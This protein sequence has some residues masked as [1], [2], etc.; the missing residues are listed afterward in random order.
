M[1]DTISALQQ[2]VAAVDALPDGRA[3]GDRQASA[4]LA[5]ALAKAREAAT[6]VPGAVRVV[7]LLEYIYPNAKDALTDQ[8]NW[9]VQGVYR[10]SAG[11]LI[12]STVLPMEVLD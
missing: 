7:R 1:I 3:G 6:M 10:P 5:E 12:R 4:Q 9:Q 11:R 2:L 8:Q